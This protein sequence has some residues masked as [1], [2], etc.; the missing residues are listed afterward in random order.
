M[1]LS[2]HFYHVCSNASVPNVYHSTLGR[3][4]YKLSTETESKIKKHMNRLK[5]KQGLN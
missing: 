2:Q 4:S 3:V 1:L 5:Q